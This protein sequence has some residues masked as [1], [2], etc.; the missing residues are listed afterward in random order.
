MVTIIK[1]KLTV[2]QEIIVEVASIFCNNQL[3]HE[4]IEA[5][6]EEDIIILE[7]QYTKK[8]RDAIH[9]IE[10]LIADSVDGDDDEEDDE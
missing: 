4:I 7:V 9:E 1:K 2:P 10:D 6:D 3:T 5:D 8:E